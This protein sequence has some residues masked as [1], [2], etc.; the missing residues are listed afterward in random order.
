M[1]PN[2]ETVGYRIWGVDNVVYG[3][4]DLPILG[5]WIHDERVTPDTWIFSERGDAWQKA[6]STPELKI[7][8]SR[9][10][11]SGAV[12]TTLTASPLVPGVKP[13]ALRRVKILAEMNDQQ[14]GRFAQMMEIQQVRQWT[15]IVKQGTPGDAM[16]LV[17]DG[18]VRVRLLIAEKETTLTTLSVG[19]F[20][21]EGS[22][23]DQGLRSADVVANHDSTLLKVSSANFEK[24]VRES[25]DLATPFLLAIC[26]TMSARIRADNKRLRDSIAFSRA[27]R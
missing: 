6:G 13:G 25:P 21:G 15:E 27:S 26:R 24:L 23:F 11:A 5:D 7:F 17:L 22:L 3:P 16:Y 2:N 14:L 18:E 1:E 9:R 12:D 19:D 10:S 20:F 8:F 4:V